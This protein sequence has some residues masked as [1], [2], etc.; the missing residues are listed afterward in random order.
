MPGSIHG[1]KLAAA[2][3][4]RW[5]PIHIIIMSGKGHPKSDEMPRA[6]Q[7]ISKPWLVRDVLQVVHRFEN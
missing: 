6:S 7:F 5:P 1:L 4:D 2:V 3:R